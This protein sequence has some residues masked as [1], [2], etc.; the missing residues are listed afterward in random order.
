MNE[1]LS[2]QIQKY[3]NSTNAG[4]MK[5]S[6]EMLNQVE[7]LAYLFTLPKDIAIILEIDSYDFITQLQDEDSPIYKAFHKG[8]LMREIEIK[9][10]IMHLED[11]YQKEFAEKQIRNF[12]A[13]LKLQLDD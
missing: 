7:Q 2:Q 10:T 5:F 3:T 8:Y 9:K 13:Q 11:A 6:V 4:S 12:K 1:E